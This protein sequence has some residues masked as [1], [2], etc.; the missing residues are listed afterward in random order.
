MPGNFNLP[1]EIARTWEN[2]QG[3][4]VRTKGFED[5]DIDVPYISAIVSTTYGWKLVRPDGDRSRKIELDGWDFIDNDPNPATNL[6]YLTA[7]RCSA[8]NAFESPA[9]GLS[10]QA[11]MPPSFIVRYFRHS[12]LDFTYDY[13]QFINAS[14]YW[15]GYNVNIPGVASKQQMYVRSSSNPNAPSNDFKWVSEGNIVLEC[16]PDDAGG[17]GFVALTPDGTKYHFNHLA[18]LP[19]DNLSVPAAPPE[20]LDAITPAPCFDCGGTDKPWSSAAVMRRVE[21][22][23]YATKVEDRFG[24]WVAYEYSGARLD[25]ITASDGRIIGLTYNARGAI[26]TAISSGRTWTYNYVDVPPEPGGWGGG[27]AVNNTFLNQVVNPDSSKWSYDLAMLAR[28]RV[29]HLENESYHGVEPCT[30]HGPELPIFVFPGFEEINGNLTTPSGATYTYTAAPVRHSLTHARGMLDNTAVCA[31]AGEPRYIDAISLIR[32]TVVGPGVPQ[33]TW[34]YSYQQAAAK[35]TSECLDGNCAEQKAVEVLS[36]DGSSRRYFYGI[37]ADRNMGS[38]LGYEVVESG[39]V[40]YKESNDY[41]YTGESTFPREFGH[42]PILF[43]NESMAYDRVFPGLETFNPGHVLVGKQFP[44]KSTIS[45]Q[46]MATF[47]RIVNSFDSYMRPL[48]VTR[49]SSLGYTR[50]DNTSYHDNIPRW[51]LGQ[52]ASV[53]N[54]ETGLVESRTDF[55]SVTALPVRQHS[56]G[57]LQQ[58][59]TYNADGTMATASDGRDGAS[60][61]TTIRLLNWKRGIP[62]LIRFPATPESPAGASQSAVVNDDA[63]LASVTDENGFKTCY[64]YDSMGRTSTVTYPSENQTGVCDTSA[65]NPTRQEFAQINALEWDIPA[66]HWRQTIIQGEGRRQ[67]YFDALWRPVLTHE[68]D[69]TNVPA[70]QRF[71]RR[72][73]DESGREAFGSYPGSTHDQTAGTWTLYDALGRVT[74]QSQDSEFGLLTT[75]T[76]YL[77]GL[78][79]RTTNPRG[80]QTTTS[81]LAWDQPST[82]MP[83]AIT[84]PENARTTI[85]RDIFGKPLWV[86]RYGAQAGQPEAVRWYVYDGFQ[87]LCKTIEPETGATV[88]DYDAAGNLVRT[89]AGL[90]RPGTGSESCA[91]DRDAAYWS[92]RRIDRYYDARNRLT[93]M[94]MPDGNGTQDWTYT[95]D[96][97]PSQIITYN[98]SGTT[99]VVNA[100]S[101]NKRR[102]L[103]GESVSQPN[104]YAWGIGYGY[105]GNASLSGHQYPTGLYVDYAPNALGQATRAGS[106]A[107]GVSYYPNG[108][109]K[110]FTYG[111]GLLHTMQQNARQLPARSTDSGGALDHQ[112]VYDNNANVQY[113][114]DQV[115]PALHRYLNYDGLDR[116]TAAG[117]QMFGGDHWHRYTYDVLDNLTSSTLGGVKDYANYV[118]DA[119]NRL[120]NIQDSGGASVIGLGYDA[121]GNLANKNGV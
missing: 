107:T 76:E 93:S 103:T 42:S 96:G 108:A 112:Y 49:S 116:L 65:W 106:W 98:D 120:T 45:V 6:Q 16:T 102:L 74:S 52:V 92:G 23:L 67:L 105:D 51:I 50:T 109:I 36:P 99:A 21:A 24:N 88:M 121:Q 55:D 95:A 115:N 44:I 70:T 5:W 82:D 85:N 100:Y 18:Y 9:Y 61:D 28:N 69:A 97:L 33:Q 90:N 56:F 27:F 47:S 22:R 15:G 80:A 26:K 114:Y 68:Y 64:A 2:D 3:A 46:D 14:Q 48:V 12:G 71:T 91:G 35:F 118:Y 10:Y 57:K 43:Q 13:K 60:I 30:P 101:Y 104:W 32:K 62:Q 34:N 11:V 119:N 20:D 37:R 25:R 53:T 54:A 72:T 4:R 31:I 113:I 66:G 29:Y 94:Q 89:A 1:V 87:Q 77:P 111:N 17:E 86:K 81:Y 78:Q 40:K 63:T 117:S 75:R 38:L 79:T 7:N 84:H 58:T 8:A 83:V 110:Q 39:S 73:F 41:F 59:L 19:Y